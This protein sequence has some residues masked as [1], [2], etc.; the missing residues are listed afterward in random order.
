MLARR[1]QLLRR[2]IDTGHAPFL[3]H[4]RRLNVAVAP[5]AAS[6][7]PADQA[8]EQ[9]CGQRRCGGARRTTHQRR[10]PPWGTPQEAR[11]RG[12]Q[13]IYAQM[14]RRAAAVELLHD[15]GRNLRGSWGAGGLPPC[16]PT[17]SGPCSC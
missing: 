6:D 1:C 3:A 7:R 8:N 5:A 13:T 14:Q 15:L 11:G 2:H 10:A 16:M 4:Q 17:S 12:A 9:H